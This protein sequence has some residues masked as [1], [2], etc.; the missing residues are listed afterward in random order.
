[1]TIDPLREALDCYQSG[2]YPAAAEAFRRLLAA[3]PDNP[4]LLRLYGLAEVRAGDVAAGLPSLKEAHRRT[5]DDPLTA[6]HLAIGLHAQGDLAAANFLLLRDLGWAIAQHEAQMRHWQSIQVLPIT[7]VAL[8]DWIE[9]FDGTLNHVLNFLGLPPDPGCWR[10]HENDRRIATAS[11]DQ[12]RRPINADGIGRWRRY[13]SQ[14]E[15]MIA[16]LRLAGL[17]T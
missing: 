16:E 3:A 5:P 11:R 12:V 8:T 17:C 13:A 10:F 1:M 4:V 14:L 2:T 6:L 9:D 7:T 15:P